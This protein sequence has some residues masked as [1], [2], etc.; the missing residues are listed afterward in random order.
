MIEHEYPPVT[1]PVVL[2]KS[3]ITQ[4]PCYDIGAQEMILSSDLNR[5]VRRPGTAV[6]SEILPGR[7]GRRQDRPSRPSI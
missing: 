3:V 1:Y 4:R 6:P 2:P 7:T 5:P